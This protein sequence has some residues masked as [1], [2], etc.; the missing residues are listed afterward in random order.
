VSELNDLLTGRIIG[1]AM[2][3][4]GTLGP[5]FL[6]SI[7]HKAFLHELEKARL[8]VESEKPIAV[9]YDNIKV[10]EFAADLIVEKSVIVELKAITSLVAAHQVQLVNYLTATKMNV[11]LL[12][13]FGS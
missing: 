11:G 5:G 3:V 10:G 8:N 4:H 13:N 12:I 9:Y 1:C 6:E 7:Y 2:K